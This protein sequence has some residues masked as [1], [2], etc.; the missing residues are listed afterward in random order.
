MNAQATDPRA[1]GARAH[2]SSSTN[3]RFPAAAFPEK[4]GVSRQQRWRRGKKNWS[5]DNHL[6]PLVVCGPV[7]LIG[8]DGV[9]LPA[10]QAASRMTLPSTLLHI[11]PAEA[12][13]RQFPQRDI[14]RIPA[15]TWRRLFMPSNRLLSMS[16]PECGE[17]T[18]MPFAVIPGSPPPFGLSRN[19]ANAVAG[20]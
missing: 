20:R 8:S 4:S 2:R 17:P 1:S 14:P 16:P 12:I 15:S 18:V 7:A 9:G 19:S 13:V 3:S 5:L 11:R 10:Q 6:G